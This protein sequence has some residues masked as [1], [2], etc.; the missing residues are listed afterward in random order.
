MNKKSGKKADDQ[1]QRAGA[2]YRTR[3]R[4]IDSAAQELE[5]DDSA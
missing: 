3:P 4:C 2:C 5:K 1:M